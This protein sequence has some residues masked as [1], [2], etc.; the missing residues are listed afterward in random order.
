[1]SGASDWNTKVIAEFRV[2]EG[3]VG[4]AFEGAPMLLLHHRGR[5]SGNDFVSPLM[6][7]RSDTEPGLTYV[8]ATK[9]GAPTN[10][11][12]YGNLVSAGSATVEVGTETYPVDVDEVT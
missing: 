1:M 3:R 8:F 4:G 12:W 2:N 7:L 9:S 10:P 6:Y 11:Q 5:R